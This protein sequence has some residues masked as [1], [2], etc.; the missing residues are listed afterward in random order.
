LSDELE[1]HKASIVGGD[2]AGDTP[3]IGLKTRGYLD[4]PQLPLKVLDFFIVLG[5]KLTLG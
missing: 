4:I 1:N 3:L 2:R 5:H